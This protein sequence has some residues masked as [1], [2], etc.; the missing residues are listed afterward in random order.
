M[1]EADTA[2]RTRAAFQL[3][4]LRQAVCTA[5]EHNVPLLERKA[6]ALCCLR[7]EHANLRAARNYRHALWIK[8]LLVDITFVG[9]F[10][11]ARARLLRELGIIA[12]TPTCNTGVNLVRRAKIYEGV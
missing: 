7:L 2:A 11:Q 4:A 6:Y 8:M 10:R 12:P 5:E 9:S 1:E 3:D